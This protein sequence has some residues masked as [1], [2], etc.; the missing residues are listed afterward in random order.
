MWGNNA[1]L[2]L[3]KGH[4]MPAQLV[5]ILQVFFTGYRFGIDEGK[6]NKKGESVD[7]WY[8]AVTNSSATNLTGKDI[9]VV[10]RWGRTVLTLGEWVGDT[11]DDDGVVRQAYAI[12]SDTKTV[13]KKALNRK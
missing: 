1:P 3:V 12:V 6:S 13:S 11:T 9:L 10:G 5:A 2:G 8:C 4:K 7:T